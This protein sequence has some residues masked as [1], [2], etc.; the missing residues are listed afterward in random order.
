MGNLSTAVI[1]ERN[2]N[3]NPGSLSRKSQTRRKFS[4]PT[5]IVVSPRKSIT[6]AT[7]E[8][9]HSVSLRVNESFSRFCASTMVSTPAN[10][11]AILVERAFFPEVNVASQQNYNV[12]Q[13][14]DKPEQPQIMVHERPRI[15]KNRLD[16]E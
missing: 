15:K 1:S 10:A 12:E 9:S 13:H 16:I 14:L 2:V 3:R 5:T 8:A 6:S 11:L 4:R 7:A